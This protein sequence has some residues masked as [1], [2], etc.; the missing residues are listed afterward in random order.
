MRKPPIRKGRRLFSCPHRSNVIPALAGIHARVRS[1]AH[2]RQVP[3]QRIWKPLLRLRECGAV[4]VAVGAI[5]NVWH[6]MLSAGTAGDALR[7]F[8]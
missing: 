3:C 6:G 4:A 1:I 8:H 5:A 7:C 2:Y